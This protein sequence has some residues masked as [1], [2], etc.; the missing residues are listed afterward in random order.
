MKRT[1]VFA[2]ALSLAFIPSCGKAQEIPLESEVREED[3]RE[4]LTP[5]TLEGQFQ[6]VKVGLPSNLNNLSNS[7]LSANIKEC[8]RDMALVGVGL[9][10]DDSSLTYSTQY[11]TME[12]ND[13]KSTNPNEDSYKT[14]AFYKKSKSMED[15]E[16]V[17]V[18]SYEDGD[19][20]YSYVSPLYLN[21]KYAGCIT[22]DL[23]G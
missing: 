15:G 5:E 10:F 20:Y 17:E 23:R 18:S 8:F 22:L 16:I 3:Q 19:V 7:D 1:I 9:W 11:Y 21:G 12:G 6:L 14:M 4:D 2:L 13:L